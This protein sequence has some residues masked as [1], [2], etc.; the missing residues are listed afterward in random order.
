MDEP[1]PAPR[2]MSTRW[3]APLN[4]RAP[5]GGRATRYSSVLISLGTPMIIVDHPH[6]L[7]TNSVA[8]PRPGSDVDVVHHVLDAGVVL[9][10]VD[11]QVL[12]VA[13][14][15]EP[16]V[17]H[18]GHHRDVGVHPHATE[19]EV[20]GEAHR[21]AVIAGPHRRGQAVVDAVGPLER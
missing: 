14:V 18:L 19:V 6:F 8:D 16:A 2:S 9:E 12:A 1:T 3:P 11:R 13:R 4:S 17:G 20:A 7:V 10:A 15:L 21:P 5:A